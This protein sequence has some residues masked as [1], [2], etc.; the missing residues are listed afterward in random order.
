[1][2]YTLQDE[3]FYASYEI[4]YGP[5]VWE[6]HLEEMKIINRNFKLGKGPLFSDKLSIWD[7][8]T[9]PRDPHT[10]T[11]AEVATDV[12]GMKFREIR[13]NLINPRPNERPYDQKF[14]CISEFASAP[15]LKEW[16]N[17]I[18]WEKV[19]DKLTSLGFKVVS[20]SK[21]KSNLKN[22]T[23]RNGDIDLAERVWY[24]HNCEFFIGVCS[25]LSWLA[26]ACGKKVV[27]ISGAT[28]EFTEFQEDNIRIIN[29][30]ACH[31]CWNSDEHRH[32]FAC[33]HSSLCPENKNFECTRKISP[34]LVIDRMYEAGL[35]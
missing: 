23:K 10:I 31:G 4:T 16:N 14:V 27:M 32:K 1:M 30:E 12:L 21:E 24:L 28:L 29:K 19:V 26:W 22:V 3:R 33:F 6:D 20:I 5:K 34:N 17:K 15:G 25:G 8:H 7:E 13:P 35:I 2:I 9:I 18:G 11:L